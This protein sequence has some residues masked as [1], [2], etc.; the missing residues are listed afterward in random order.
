MNEWSLEIKVKIIDALNRTVNWWKIQEETPVPLSPILQVSAPCCHLHT[1]TLFAEWNVFL[2]PRRK[3]GMGPK[4]W[5]FRKCN[6][7]S[8]SEVE[9][10]RQGWLVGLAI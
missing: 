3:W 8:S 5:G 7:K 2:Q 6:W 10:A 4:I 9:V 1:C